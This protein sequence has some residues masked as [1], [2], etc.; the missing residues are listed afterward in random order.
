MAEHLS[1]TEPIPFPG[2]FR[3][4]GDAAAQ[5][6]AAVLLLLGAFLEYDGI[7]PRE[8]FL[9]R[10][11]SLPTSQILPEEDREALNLPP[12][13]E[14]LRT[15]R[16]I[17][18]DRGF[19]RDS[20]SPFATVLAEPQAPIEERAEGAREAL[21]QLAERLASRWEPL[22]AAQL[23]EAALSHPDE[24]VRVAAASSYADI[25]LPG[26]RSSLIAVLVK[27]TESEDLLVRDVAAT[28]LA[29]L[30]PDHPRL[31]E[32]VYPST[33][34]RDLE[35]SHTSLIVHGTFARHGAWWQPGIQGNFHDY[36]KSKVDPSL[37]SQADRFEWSG[38]YSDH[39]RDVAALELTGWV[40]QH[41][42]EGLDLF[43]HSHGGSVAMQANRVGAVPFG[44]L[45]LLSCPVHLSKYRPDF[46]GLKRAVSIRVHLD[47][48]I[49]ADR[50]GQRF[51]GVPIKEIVL[52]IWFKH[53][54]THEPS[55]WNK[56]QLPKKI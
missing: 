22:V 2:A 43:T 23:C 12:E 34:S 38:F 39:A 36:L 16:G 54:I 55:T 1:V 45:V 53:S 35:P 6:Q 42:L 3:E 15:V 51:A 28:A 41:A 56:Y 21:P 20:L 33:P 13:V 47:L 30:S 37:Y 25:V 44:R 18:F 32:L 9:P 52:P 46:S 50:G 10:R 26:Q 4:T 5:S 8:A 11:R 29:R 17:A 19:V 7:V 40:K 31:A 49:L 24:L 27:G 48:V 14:S